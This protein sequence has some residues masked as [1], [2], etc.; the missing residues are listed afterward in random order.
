MNFVNKMILGLAV[1]LAVPVAFAAGDDE[2][3]KHDKT[4]TWKQRLAG[5]PASAKGFYQA[6]PKA[7]LV[8]GGVSA[9]A[10]IGGLAYKYSK[11]TREAVNSAVKSVRD[12]G[13]KYVVSPVSSRL[14][15]RGKQAAAGVGS[16]VTAGLAYL[17]Y[18]YIKTKKA[19]KA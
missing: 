17:G 3:P 10:L 16:V 13:S 12:A 11:K 2:S 8:A 4:V 9:A 19:A 6:H 18:N 7:C 14:N 1:F 5:I 15:T